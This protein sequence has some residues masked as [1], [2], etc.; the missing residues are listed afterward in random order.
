M[1]IIHSSDWHIGRQF[2]NVSLL[3]DQRHALKQL[4]EYIQQQQVDVLIIAGDIYDRSVPPAAA[5]ALLDEVLTN[6]CID[7]SVP[8][9]IIPGNHDSAQRLS[10][11]ARQ[12]KQTGLH[13]LAELGAITTPVKI[14]KGS[15]TCC[16]YGIPYNYPEHV[17]NQFEISVSSYEDAQ[18]YLMGLINAEKDPSC[19]NIVISHCFVE[20]AEASESERPLSIGG[21]D[22]VSSELF[23]GFDYAALGHLHQAQYKGAENI[24][25]S[26]SL[27]KYS[28]SEQQ[29]NKS[30][31]LIE[32]HDNKLRA[33]SQLPLKPL[34]DLRVI[35][36]SMQTILQQA[37]VDPHSDDYLLVRLTDAHAIMDAMGKLRQVYPNVLH[38]EKPG[39]LAVDGNLLLSR[40]KLKHSELDLFQDF[41]QQITGRSMNEQQFAAVEQIIRQLQRDQESH[42]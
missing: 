38:L 17:R 12:L 33:I 7:L 6:I 14:Q 41:Y 23:K 32:L 5:V 26:G 29:H 22:R 8:V 16:F 15:E 36:G 3:E 20:G 39:M 30:L 31:T 10:F 11:G 28:F 21:A 40:E 2:H 4:I 13:I 27:L 1:K 37:N 19:V 35:E 24:R 25:Y 42:P 18:R 9:I 34:H